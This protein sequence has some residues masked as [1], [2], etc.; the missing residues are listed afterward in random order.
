MVRPPHTPAPCAVLLPVRLPAA[1]LLV[2]ACLCTPFN[3]RR[4]LTCFAT[5]ATRCCRRAVS[6]LGVAASCAEEGRGG[7]EEVPGGTHE[8]VWR[9]NYTD[10]IARL[11][12]G[13]LAEYSVERVGAARGV[14]SRAFQPVNARKYVSQAKTGERQ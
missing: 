6:L 2:G 7:A 13:P 4:V 5:V 11:F 1:A 3:V 14:I 9:D 12:D 8:W 10:A